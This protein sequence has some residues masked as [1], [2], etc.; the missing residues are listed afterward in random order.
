MTTTTRRKRTLSPE[1]LAA[2]GTPHV[3]ATAGTAPDGAIG[4][5]QVLSAARNRAETGQTAPTVVPEGYGEVT[6]TGIETTGDVGATMPGAPTILDGGEGTG[7]GGTTYSA[8]ATGLDEGGATGEIDPYRDLDQMFE[9]YARGVFDEVDTSEEEAQLQAQQ[10]RLLGRGLV[11]TRAR[12]GE[13]GFAAGGLDVAL[14]N[15]ARREA[16]EQLG[17]NISDLRDREGEQRRAA[18]EGAMGLDIE[19]QS[20]A[21]QDAILKAQMEALAALMDQNGEAPPDGGGEGGGDDLGTSINEGINAIGEGAADLLGRGEGARE[22]QAQ[23]GALHTPGVPEGANV[24]EYPEDARENR[25]AQLE[26][27]GYSWE[28]VTDDGV[29]VYRNDKGERLYVRWS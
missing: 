3:A 11:D 16:A 25:E 7:G 15:T 5:D 2:G 19:K 6:G 22:Q 17:L 14:E 8:D 4:G 13:A 12:M 27:S 23:E 20:S 29:T 1:E 18:I 21:R 28:T 9:D 24:V 26:A 10:D